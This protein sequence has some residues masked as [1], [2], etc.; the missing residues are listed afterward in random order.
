MR[1]QPIHQVAQYIKQE[2]LLLPAGKVLVALS[3]GADSVA[4]LRILLSLGYDCEAAHCNFRL[5]GEESDRDEAFVRELCRELHI[6]LHVTSFET[7]QYAKEKRIS[8][9]MAARE[10]RYDWFAEIKET[11]G[12]SAIAVAHHKDDNAE[13]LL[14]NLIRGTGISGL[15]GI[16]PKKGDIVRPL[17]CL[18]RD[19]ITDYL[20]HIK[21]EYVT[22]STNLQDDYTRNKIRLHILPLMRE[23]NPSIADS[24]VATG[25]YL[26][27]VGCI[28][29]KSMEESKAR[30]LVAEGILIEALLREPSPRALL[31]EILHP[32]G[33]NSAQ[34]E[35]VF[36]S[37]AGQSGKQFASKEWRVIKD[38]ELLYIEKRGSSDED[39]P[40]FR[41][42]IKEQT[43]SPE[44]VIPRDKRSACFDA[45]K[46]TQP[47]TVRKVRQGDVFV[48][49]GMEGT[50]LV[51]DY[52]TDR[53]FSL[54]RKEQ[55]WA[56]CVAG[57][58]IV[59]LIGER[60]D[61]RFRVDDSTR[62]VIVV[63][64]E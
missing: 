24:L 51:S 2:K 59:W 6:P 18:S 44:F 10:L 37:L 19:E 31:F 3:G 54:P 11:S 16:R 64:L 39:V 32:L 13:T 62:R 40:P 43:L 15:C 27:E 5:R 34:T 8:I 48:P 53:K 57:E 38:R 56:L 9:E 20:R 1:Q 41:L 28:Y 25:K 63:T 21:Q 22:D 23:I 60:T 45:D 46:I 35:D 42:V 33:F 29:H 30:V 36:M 14:L 49:F 61:D 58:E 47:F 55:Q 52:L 7:S 26:S 17:L 50:K 4:L 12:A